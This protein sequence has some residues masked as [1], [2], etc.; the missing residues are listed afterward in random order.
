[1]EIFINE[2]AFDAKLETEKNV[3][4][5]FDGIRNWVESH[6]KFLLNCLVDGMEME[7][8]EM[9]SISIASV[10]R[11]DFFI[12]EEADMLLTAIK[13]L[14]EYI[15]AVG[16]TLYERDSLTDSEHKD[17]QEGIQWTEGML[18]SCGNLL[19]LDFS[20]IKPLG[21]GRN[22]DEILAEIRQNS[23]ELESSTQIE[24]F[25]ESL[26]DL[27]VFV[28]D[29]SSRTTALLFTETELREI[30][31]GSAQSVT[32]LKAEFAKVNELY[33]SGKDA[34]ANDLLTQTTGKLNVVLTSLISYSNRNRDI[35]YEE[36]ELEGEVFGE[37]LNVLNEAFARI[38]VA[39]EEN[40]IVTA[41]DILEY[42]LPEILDEIIPYLKT[43][44]E[45]IQ[46]TESSGQ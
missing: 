4:E 33:Q 42:E 10:A 7:K 14:D 41:G 46:K 12:G 32:E 31:A 2:Q 13:S 38:A 44:H 36:I 19:K 21:R 28:M 30:I 1:M 39:M 25:L 37:K 45:M 43:I 20:K 26:R 17:L 16:N 27:K 29:L 35:K 18:A 34:L 40:D 6:E 23:R 24:N 9:D 11:M 5:V 15:D 3:G 22:V 8:N